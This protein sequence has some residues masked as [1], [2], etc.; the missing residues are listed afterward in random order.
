MA[1]FRG[2]RC[3]A[4][5]FACTERVRWA[6]IRTRVND[7][8]R[9]PTTSSFSYF[10]S[11]VW[12]D[13]EPFRDYDK[14]SAKVNIL[15]VIALNGLTILSQFYTCGRSCIAAIVLSACIRIIA[16]EHSDDEPLSEE[17][18]RNQLERFATDIF[19]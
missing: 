6:E 15:E 3:K 8:S 18:F 17:I 4:R 5:L 19:G 11:R 1:R 14:R 10:Y 2:S 16:E 13:R 7:Y 12:T 9:A